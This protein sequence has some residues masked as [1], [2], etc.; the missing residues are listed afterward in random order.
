MKRPLHCQFCAHNVQRMGGNGGYND[1]DNSFQIVLL[2]FPR[3]C[4]FLPSQ[5]R[6][7]EGFGTN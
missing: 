3:H 4:F 1:R 2:V 5:G 7:E 6:W